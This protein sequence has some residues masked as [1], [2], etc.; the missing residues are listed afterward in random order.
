MRLLGYDSGDTEAVLASH[1]VQI[2]TGEG[3]WI[4]KGGCSALLALLGF[5]VRWVSHSDYLSH[6]DYSLF[7]NLFMAVGIVER[8]VHSKM[9]NF[10]DDGD[11]NQLV[12][13]LITGKR[14]TSSRCHPSDLQEAGEEILLV[15]GVDAFF[16]EGFHNR[17]YCPCVTLESKAVESP[18]LKIWAHRA[19]EMDATDSELVLLLIGEE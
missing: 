9:K 4:V 17:T 5:R 19:E 8:V 7:E 10:S 2:R 6:R 15:D 3:K 14:L 12:R 16:G 1:V 13:D 18:F 11:I